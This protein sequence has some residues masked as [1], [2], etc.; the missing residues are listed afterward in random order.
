MDFTIEILEDEPLNISSCPEEV[1]SLEIVSL[2]EQGLPGPPGAQGIPGF[3]G[4][5]YGKAGENLSGGR[6]VKTNDFGEYVYSDDI[7]TLGI[8]TSAALS[9]DDIEVIQSGDLEDPAWNFVPRQVIYQGAG[10]VLTQTLP[11]IGFIFPLGRAVT[12]TKIVVS[13]GIPIVSS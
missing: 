10:G 6:A 8:T 2:S 7:T 13:L 5:I 12:P 4:L 1:E 11:N 9:G 3:G